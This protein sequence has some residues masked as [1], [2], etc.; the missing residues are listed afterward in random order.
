MSGSR[1]S[2]GNCG[3]SWP[4]RP[5]LAVGRCLVI[6]ICDILPHPPAV[7][8]VSILTVKSR[9]GT[10]WCRHGLHP[11]THPAGCHPSYQLAGTSTGRDD[12]KGRRQGGCSDRFVPGPGCAFRMLAGLLG[13]DQGPVVG[14]DLA[15]LRLTGV[16][17]SCWQVVEL[18]A[19]PEDTSGSGREAGQHAARTSLRRKRGKEARQER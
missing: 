1:G 6:R 7:R 18:G 4:R 16:P 17:D 15:T 2:S 12:R 10:S 11:H 13:T 8:V 14:H 19:G 5:A 3:S 9:A